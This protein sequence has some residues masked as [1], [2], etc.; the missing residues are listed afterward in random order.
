[1]TQRGF[2][3]WFSVIYCLLL[4]SVALLGGLLVTIIWMLY[5]TLAD[6][7]AIFTGDGSDYDL[8]RDHGE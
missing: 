2:T 6:L 1:M 5:E 7:I 3:H 8:I 4:V